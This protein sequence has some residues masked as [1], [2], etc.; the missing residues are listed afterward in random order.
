MDLGRNWKLDKDSETD[1]QAVC[2]WSV[3]SGLVWFGSVWCVGCL[4]GCVYRN[5][6]AVG[7]PVGGFLLFGAPVA[8]G[9][10]I[11]KAGQAGRRAS[12]LGKLSE[13]RTT[14]RQAR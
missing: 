6:G 8:N 3:W 14:G 10:A 2:A 13:P 1:G 12:R 11:A 9:I 5:S 4:R 7:F